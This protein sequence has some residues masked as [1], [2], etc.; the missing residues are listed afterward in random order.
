MRR[1]IPSSASLQAFNAAAR[2]GN[3]ARASEELS[4]T[5]GAISRQIA[6]LEALLNCKLFDRVGSRV[7][8]NPVGARYAHHVREILERLERDTQYILGLPQGSQSLDIA[9]L[10]TF[11]SRWL[12]PRLNSFNALF[13]AITLNIAARTDPFILPGSGYDAVIHFEHSAWAG[14]RVQFLFQENLL[15]VCHPALLTDDDVN[16][17]LNKLPRIHRRQNPDAW[18]RYAQESGIEL[19]NPAQGARYDLHEMAIAAVM[20]GQGV[21]LVPRMYIENELSC[22]TL[23]SPWP[24]SDS[25]SKRFCLIKPTDTHISEPALNRFERWLL[26]EMNTHTSNTKIW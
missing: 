12:I 17:Q 1:K 10:P 14:M 15:P 2:H 13:P 16:Q 9:V 23:V 6:R 26:A 25:L 8:L 20:A 11:A 4:L 18:H 22:G 7:K 3:F 24:A 19:D 5:E 21:A